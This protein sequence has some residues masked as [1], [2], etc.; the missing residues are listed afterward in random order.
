ME[1]SKED[2]AEDDDDDEEEDDDNEEEESDSEEAS[3]DAKPQEQEV[4]KQKPAAPAPKPNN[5]DGKKK[6]FVV[7]VGNL[8]FTANR[9]E[10]GEHFKKVG[11]IVDIRIPM[12]QDNKP[13]GFAYVEVRDQ[14][15]YEVRGFLIIRE[16]YASYRCWF[17]RNLCLSTAHL[18]E[19]ARLG[20]SIVKVARKTLNSVRASSSPRT[21]NSRRWRQRDNSTAAKGLTRSDHL[22]V[23]TNRIKIE[24]GIPRSNFSL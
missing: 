1:A 5:S 9:E 12:S 22:G 13:R 3:D 20:S 14:P 21:S 23:E 7:F 15:A 4:V 11:E 6:R 24:T 2:D 10:I 8:P 16:N 19:A 17:F 18:W